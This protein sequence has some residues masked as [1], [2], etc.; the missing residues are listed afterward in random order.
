MMKRLV[1]ISLVLFCCII[2]PLGNLAFA[3]DL[4][5]G[6]WGGKIVKI[7][8]AG[9]K[10]DFVSGISMTPSDLA[11]D[12]SGNLYVSEAVN[13]RVEKI[14]P[15]GSRSVFAS[16][17]AFPTGL[18]FDVNNNLFVADSEFIYKYAPDGSRTTFASGLSFINDLAFD[19]SGNLWVGGNSL[20]KFTP[21]GIKT[22]IAGVPNNCLT[23]DHSD[24]VFFTSLS[25][26]ICKMTPSGNPTVF[27][28]LEWT[29]K[30]NLAFDASGNLF[31]P[32]M[33]GGCIYE[34]APD[35]TRSLF[36]SGLNSP[37]TL[38]FAPVPEPAT[39]ILLGLGSVSLLTF[40]RRKR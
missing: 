35:G 34:F 18:A 11:F 13:M 10:S 1:K 23:I 27:A 30:C 40:G 9:E 36:A 14:T 24:N 16:E 5:V 8:P 19:S 6:G 20:C 29:T 28:Q 7:T 12:S 32:D 26:E 3:A 25:G 2:L 21:E 37:T 39:L 15:S 22:T 4:Y 17:L 33:Q 38:A 31:V